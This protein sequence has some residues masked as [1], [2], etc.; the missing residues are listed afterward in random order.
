ME[1]LFNIKVRE[2]KTKRMQQLDARVYKEAMHEVF[3]ELFE[4]LDI[5]VL[6]IQ[7]GLMLEIP[8]E[9]YG[10]IPIEAKF[11]IKPLNTDTNAYHEQFMEKEAERK[12]KAEAK[13]KED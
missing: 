2:T 3:K 12:A 13:K 9:E 7:N 4:T 1:R 10:S 5:D 6:E 8:H 11:V